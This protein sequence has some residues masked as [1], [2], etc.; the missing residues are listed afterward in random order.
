[1]LRQLLEHVE[2]GWQA[3][4]TLQITSEAVAEGRAVDERVGR[5]VAFILRDLVGAFRGCALTASVLV[6]GT[7]APT[8]GVPLLDEA[9]ES[10]DRYLSVLYLAAADPAVPERLTETIR[11]AADALADWVPEFAVLGT[12]SA[13]E[14]P[15][16]QPI[17]TGSAH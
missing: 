3:V 14:Q 1:V 2:L 13:A 17:E 6:P 5:L 10:F 4:A 7:A 9:A 12:A 11:T 15:K 8:D 16:V